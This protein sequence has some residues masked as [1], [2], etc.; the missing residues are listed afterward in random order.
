MS[1]QR[2]IKFQLWLN[3]DEEKLLKEKAKKAGLSCSEFLRFTLY[4]VT[5]LKNNQLKK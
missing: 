3:A 5:N 2:S 4:T 1:R